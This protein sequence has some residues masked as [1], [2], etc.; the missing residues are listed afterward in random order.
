M[1]EAK[2]RLAS[3]PTPESDAE[4]LLSRMLGIS[5]AELRLRQHEEAKG[6]LE[7]WRAWLGRR[8]AGEPVQYV[9]GR[10]AFREGHWGRGLVGPFDLLVSNPPY[11]A[12]ADAATLP[13]EVRAF[14]P[15]EALFAGADGLEAYCSLGPD[16]ARLLARDGAA[17]LEIGQGQG[18]S[19]TAVMRR[20]GLQLVA[21][22][23]DLAGIERCLIFR[24]VSGPSR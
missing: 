15:A 14:E 10:A 7:R 9:T 12:R 3:S 16:C 23:S 13:P 17:C 19:V 11:V 8:A 6:D 5:R 20:Q 4:E 1:T 21:S 18:A 22:R 24:P 2:E